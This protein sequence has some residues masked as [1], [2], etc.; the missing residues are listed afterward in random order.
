[1]STKLLRK[2]KIDKSKLIKIIDEIFSSIMYPIRITGKEKKIDKN[3]GIDI[4][5]TG[6]K[7]F[8]ESSKVSE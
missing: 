8:N 7:N 5:L 2:S 4:K 1:M 6:I 3:N